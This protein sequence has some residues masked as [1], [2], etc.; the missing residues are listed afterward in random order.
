M[1]W[2]LEANTHPGQ[3]NNI[4]CVQFEPWYGL[5]AVLKFWWKFRDWH[6]KFYLF[7]EDDHEYW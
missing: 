2:N 4:G 5:I 1:M 3:K 7:H 6:T